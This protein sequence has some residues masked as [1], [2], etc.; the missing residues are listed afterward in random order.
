MATPDLFEEPFDPEDYVERLA[1]RQ[2][3]GGSKGGAENFDPQML[4]NVFTHTIEEL[5]VLNEKTQRR[6][7]KLEQLSQKE[8]KEHKARVAELQKLNQ[9]ALNQ[10]QELDERINHI[11]TKVVHLG[12]Q[13]EGVNIPRARAVEAEKLMKYFSEFLSGDIKSD[14]FT[15]PFRLQEAADIIQKL[16]LIAQELP[17]DKFDAAKDRIA[18]KYLE[19]ESNLVEQFKTAHQAGQKE[20]MKEVAAVLLNFKGYSHCIDAFIFQ[21]QKHAMWHTDV[22]RG[23]TRLCEEVNQLVL[24]VF[25][26][27]ENVMGKFVL[28][29]YEGKLQNHIQ[30]SLDKHRSDTEKYLKTLFQLFQ[31]TSQLSADLSKYK[32]GSDTNFLN[33]LTK[34]I[35]GKYLESYIGVETTF[36][37]S[38]MD[39][40]LNR[41]YNSINHQKR[42]I[43]SG[44][45]HDLQARIRNKTNLNIGP[46]IETYGGETFLSQEVA[47]N[48]LQ[49]SKEALKR[50]E[51]LSSS[52]DLPASAVRIFDILFEKLCM[53]HIDYAVDIGL[54]AIS[55]PEP[56][57]EPEIYF[58]DVVGQG[59]A[60]FHLLEKQFSDALVPLIISTPRYQ[61]AV[62]RKREIMELIDSKLDGGLDR[63]ITA[64]VGWIKHIL[65]TEQKKTDFRPEDD[66][67]LMELY[68]PACHKVTNF[69]RKEIIKMRDSLDGKN[70][71]ATLTEF[72]VRFHRLVYE[73][74]QQFTYNPRGGMLAICDVNEYRKC[75]KDELKVA[76]VDSLFETLHALCNLLVVVPDNL[77][78]VCTGEQLASLDRSVVMSFVQLRADHKTGRLG[79]LFADFAQKTRERAG[80]GPSEHVAL[81]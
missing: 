73:H 66:S 61:E 51:L 68:T 37:K 32:L 31:Q 33:K 10:F 69:I 11:A 17:P 20:E 9:M 45:I 3:G 46:A 74:L 39:I 26:Q 58:F 24:D 4:L 57:T 29:V 18:A 16:H 49:E 79:K 6:V 23:I 8:E 65:T 77:K 15:D 52:K 48:L 53:E 62:T 30:E 22:F 13:L 70:L 78:L 43:P 75:V 36:L 71:D 80:T 76:L 81:Q 60:I 47:I 64:M 1:W 54:Q 67:A 41:Y 28:N 44:G 34:H 7:E 40:I 14:V 38:R 72:G 59:N 19:I 63:T 21:S 25:S 42:Q 56:K 50:C 5:K 2:H 12:D 55:I 27:P 35:F